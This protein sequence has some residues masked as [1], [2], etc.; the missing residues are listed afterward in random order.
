MKVIEVKEENG[1][2]QKEKIDEDRFDL[3]VIAG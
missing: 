1:T 3:K 2:F